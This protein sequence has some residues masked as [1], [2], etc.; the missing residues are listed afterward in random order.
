MSESSY[1]RDVTGLDTELARLYSIE[2]NTVIQE[3]VIRGL[4]GIEPA[5]CLHRYSDV[6]T[7]CAA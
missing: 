2:Y 4:D 7:A 5:F 1:T 3:Y 6:S